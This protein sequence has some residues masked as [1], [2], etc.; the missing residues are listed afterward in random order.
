MKG[1]L[2]VAM[3]ALGIGAL[4]AY[5]YYANRAPAPAAAGAPGLGAKGPGGA[6]GGMP[7]PVEVAPVSVG[8]VREIVDAVGTLRSNESVVVR[9]EISGHIDR[10]GFTEGAAVRKGQVI[11]A[12]DDAV[13]A[14]ELAQ[15]KANLALAESNYVRTREL[16]KAKFVSA[17]AKDRAFN[18]LRVPT[19]Y[20][21]IARRRAPEVLAGAAAASPGA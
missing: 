14:A 7:L 16:E 3:A 5:A 15:A 12:L 10:L 17:A 4:A 18:T 2:V 11:V 20:S 1:S 6:P 21:L 9:P 8:T 19:V 13:P